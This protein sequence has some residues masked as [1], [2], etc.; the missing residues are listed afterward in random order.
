MEWAG[1]G[2]IGAGT[3][4]R[5]GPLYSYLEGGDRVEL[6]RGGVPMGPGTLT[7]PRSPAGPSRCAPAC[8]QP[9]PPR[10]SRGRSPRCAAPI[11]ACGPCPCWVGDCRRTATSGLQRQAYSVPFRS[12]RHLTPRPTL[13]HCRVG[14][15]RMEHGKWGAWEDQGSNLPSTT[16]CPET[17]GTSPASVSLSSSWGSHRDEPGAG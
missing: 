17:H 8:D 6:S 12:S 7:W 1:L 16:Y 11:R 10:S 14:A 5:W 13:P 15:D 3:R 4:E 2:L 9:H